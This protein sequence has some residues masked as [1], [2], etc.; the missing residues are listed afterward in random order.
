[1]GNRRKSRTSHLRWVAHIIATAVLSR[2]PRDLSAREAQET[3]YYAIWEMLDIPA[4][5]TSDQLQRI[6]DSLWG[7]V[8]RIAERDAHV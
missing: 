3:A 2:E 5:L 1:M 8:Q 6:G 4:D 7:A